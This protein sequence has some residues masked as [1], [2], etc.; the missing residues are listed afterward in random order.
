MF[1]NIVGFKILFENAHDQNVSIFHSSGDICEKA[2]THQTS[3]I[4]FT[5]SPKTISVFLIPHIFQCYSSLKTDR[6]TMERHSSI[7]LLSFFAIL[8]IRRPPT[9]DEC[10]KRNDKPTRP[11]TILRVQTFWCSNRIGYSLMYL[12]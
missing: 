6:K 11:F 1:S 7:E 12:V 4:C 9:L 8:Y 5:L 10:Y 3:T 2:L